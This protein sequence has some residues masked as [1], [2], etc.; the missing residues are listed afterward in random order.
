[1][2]DKILPLPQ[3]TLIKS[4]VCLSMSRYW[5]VTKLEP[6]QLPILH[7]LDCK[8]TGCLELREIGLPEWALSC[9]IEGTILV[10]VEACSNGSGWDQVDWW[11]A[12]FI[13]LE[14]WHERTWELNNGTIHSYSF[15]LEGW[16]D[17]AW[18]RAWVNRIALFM[19]IWSARL[20]G[21]DAEQLFGALPVTEIILTHD[22]DAISKT[23]AIRIKQSV[24][25]LFNAGKHLCKLELYKA[26]N[27]LIKSIGFLVGQEDWWTFDALLVEEKKAGICAHFNFYADIRKKTLQRWLFDPAYDI[28]EPRVQK[29]MQQILKQNGVIG[30]HPTFDAWDLSDRIYQQRNYLS[31]VSG[32][33]I[34][35]CRQHWLQLSW[36]NTW[37]AQE[38]AGIKVDT[39]LMFNNRSGF[40]SSAALSYHPWNQKKQSEHILVSQPSVLMDSHLYDYQAMDALQRKQAIMNWIEE[41]RN[42]HGQIAVLWH[43]HTLTKDFG[44]SEGFHDLINILNGNTPCPDLH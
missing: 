39:T 26:S 6:E 42:V 8:I 11:L 36:Q 3:Y 5:S 28:G 1:M 30:L 2:T 16:D 9:G 44:W 20:Q 24:F 13:L 31:T 32:Q 15:R 23:L 43:P 29:L 21:Q 4:H 27:N 17:R 38:N 19:R 25:N 10:P 37:E 12:A 22:V 40:R 14:C 7:A 18:D 33:L 35:S 41:T 34:K